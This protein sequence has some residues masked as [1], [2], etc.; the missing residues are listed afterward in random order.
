[1][2]FAL[3]GRDN[4]EVQPVE[5]ANCVFKLHGQVFRLNNVQVDR[6]VVQDRFSFVKV[7]LHGGGVPVY[8][9]LRPGGMFEDAGFRLPGGIQPIISNEHTL[10]FE[11]SEPDR[12]RRAWQYVYSHGCVGQKSP[13]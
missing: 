11:T 9:N 7:E 13:F 5:R 3:T 1:M 12:V 4:G 10:S 2:R 6:L 8:E